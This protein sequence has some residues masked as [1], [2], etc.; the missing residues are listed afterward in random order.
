MLQRI[1]SGLILAIIVGFALFHSTASYYVLIALVIYGIT[2]EISS[3]TKE[4]HSF[5]INIILLTIVFIVTLRQPFAFSNPPAPYILIS[6]PLLLVAIE[7]S[8]GALINTKIIR[9]LRPFI[10]LG[11]V[12]PY[13]LLLKQIPDTTLLLVMTIV[14]ISTCDSSAYFIGRAFGKRQLSPISPK[15]TVEGSLG[16][17][18]GAILIVLPFSYYI[19]LPIWGLAIF[20]MAIGVLSQIGDLHESLFKRAYNIKDSS[21]LIPGHGGIYD[22]T[23]S[24]LYTVPIVYIIASIL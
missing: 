7:L 18:F 14:V 10:F 8:R 12:T 24:Y 13:F 9:L 20:A 22:R 3:I 2:D 23:D 11:P 21:N 17:I 1:I 5:I 15:K 16:G 6:I 19:S 4:K